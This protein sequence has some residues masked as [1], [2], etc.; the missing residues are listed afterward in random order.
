MSFSLRHFE[1]EASVTRIISAALQAADPGRA[2]R[3]FVE[4]HGDQ[5]IIAGQAY[6]LS[7]FHRVWVVGAGKAG[8]SMA[9]AV[10][11]IL[12]DRLEGG[13]VV[14]KDG[15]IQPLQGWMSPK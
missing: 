6:E 14:V 9:G 1:R 13:V 10:G 7:A 5:L 4:R 3:R 12:G 15:Y 11:A 8:A 2:V